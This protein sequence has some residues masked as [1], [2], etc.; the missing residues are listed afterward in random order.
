MIKMVNEAKSLKE[1]VIETEQIR[2]TL[3]PEI[4]C[5]IT[6][7][8]FLRYDFQWLWQDKNRPVRKPDYCGDYASYDISGFDEC[9]PNIGLSEYPDDENIKLCDHGEIWARPWNVTFED[10]RLHGSVELTG[11]PLEFE[12]EISLNRETIEFKYR[13]TN[14]G[15][16]TFDYMWSAHPLFQLPNRYRVLLPSGQKMY[17][18]FGF[19]G[20][21]GPD[22]D[23]GYQDHLK[24]LTWPNVETASGEMVDL[25]E[26]IPNLGVTDKVAVT[27][28]G[29][30]ALYLVNND[31]AAGL[32]FTFSKEISH[33]G[34][35]SNLTAW[36]PGPHPATWIAIEPMI[37]ISDRLDENMA[38]GTSKSIGT[39]ETQ[40]WDFSI[41]LM[42]LEKD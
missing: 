9:F 17:K 21:L 15:S 27:A 23:D 30:E 12:R 8:E 32:K 28:A 2:L 4:G 29:I 6:K 13:V 40:V 38:M 25:T 14:H 36:P 10:N 7:L 41:T 19:G 1:V 34:I 39:G 42:E 5:K 33:V 24:E 16:K 20:R 3:L 18:E 31:L 37:G 26:V 35:C 11:M 22:G